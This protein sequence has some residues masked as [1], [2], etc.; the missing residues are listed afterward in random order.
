VK[1]K[2]HPPKTGWRSSTSASSWFAHFSDAQRSSLFFLLSLP[3][4]CPGELVDRRYSHRRRFRGPHWSIPYVRRSCKADWLPRGAGGDY[5]PSS[6]VAFSSLLCAKGR[7]ARSGAIHVR[8]MDRII[9]SN[10]RWDPAT[11]NHIQPRR[12]ASGRAFSAIKWIICRRATIFSLYPADRRFPSNRS[13]ASG[14]PARSLPCLP[15]ILSH[16]PFPTTTRR[17]PRYGGAP[18]QTT[19]R[20][21]ARRR[22][23]LQPGDAPSF[24]LLVILP[25]ATVPPEP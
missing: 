13:S 2:P 25:H 18:I 20:F 23:S 6:S 7:L 11:E 17:P 12:L 5:Q 1:H 15:S 21:T 24:I 16:T 10:A 3:L 9:I 19:F 8:A 14:D 4:T 22:R